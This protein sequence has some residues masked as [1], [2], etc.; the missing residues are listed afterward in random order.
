MKISRTHNGISVSLSHSIERMLHKFDF[1]N[2][3]PIF[4]PYDFSIALKKNMD[5]P[6]SQLKYSQLMVHFSIF[7]TGL[8]VTSLMQ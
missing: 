7:L 6:V 1:Y 2:S 5:E 4:T 3:E 8:G